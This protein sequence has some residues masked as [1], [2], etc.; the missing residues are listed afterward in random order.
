M[1]AWI[2]AA[3][4]RTLPLALS[5]IILG[6]FLA[7][8]NG[9]FEPK[10]CVLAVLT[11]VTLQVLSNFAN[12]YGDSKN[13]ADSKERVGPK[14]AVQSGAISEK[15]MFTAIVICGLVSFLLGFS[16]IYSAFGGFNSKYFQIFLGIGL[17]CILA[18]YFYTA[19]KRPYGYVGLGDISV[20]VFFGLVGV[21]GT[22]FLY[23]QSSESIIL[24]PAFACGALA[25][26]VLNLNN[27]R[28]LESDK[29]AG[30]ITIPVRIGRKNAIF[31]H[32]FLLI[33]AMICTVVFL[34]IQN[35]SWYYLL[36]FPLLI[37]NGIQVGKSTNPDPYLKTLA[38]SSVFFSIVFGLSLVF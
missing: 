31:Y 21:F 22:Y 29:L 4:P 13:G 35:G 20:F 28:D 17:A 30:K 11:T 37:L 24:L 2:S 36:S 1:K 38:L 25:T 5:S 6:S 18:A 33:T 15:Q 27:I 8:S 23:T 26:A 14:R 16:L 19:G 3:R 9:S 34:I 12:D 32:W 7:A 10:I